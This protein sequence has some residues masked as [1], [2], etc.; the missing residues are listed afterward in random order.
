MLHTMFV[1]W[2]NMTLTLRDQRR[3]LVARFLRMHKVT[4]KMVFDGWHV[5]AISDLLAMES[6]ECHQA[7]VQKGIAKKWEPG[8]KT[9]L[10]V[11]TLN[12]LATRSG[13]LP[14]MLGLRRQSLP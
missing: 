13:R 9:F 11:T 14:S 4:L 1:Q 6:I 2:H 5:V 12:T 3:Q 7:L 8:M 10:L